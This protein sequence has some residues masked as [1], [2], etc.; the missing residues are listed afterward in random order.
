MINTNVRATSHIPKPKAWKGGD[1]CLIVIIQIVN[2]IIASVKIVTVHPM[3]SVQR[4]V[5]LPTK[6]FT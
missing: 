5:E 2:V 1:P 3:I 6:Y 4:V